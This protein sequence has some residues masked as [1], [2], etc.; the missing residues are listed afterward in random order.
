MRSEELQTQEPCRQL[1]LTASPILCDA[2]RRSYTQLCASADAK[3]S[4]EDSA[5]ISVNMT[6]LTNAAAEIPASMVQCTDDRFPL[7]TTYARFI[8]MLDRCLDRSF[9]QRKCYCGMNNREINDR[10]VTFERF[11]SHYYPQ[12]DESMKESVST[13][14][15]ELV[16][17]I[18][19]SIGALRTERGY[20]DVGD[21][22]NM[23]DQRGS[24]INRDRR[25]LIYQSFLKYERLKKESSQFDHLDLVHHVYRGLKGGNFE[26]FKMCRSVFIDEV[27]GKFIRYILIMNNYWFDDSL[28]HRF[29]SSGIG[30]AEIRM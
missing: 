19:G 6:H 7:I 3:P 13:V 27:Q 17:S 11:Q 23:S 30:R 24:S 9:F 8:R 15:G 2:I 12:F 20:I 16:S 22:E 26:E 14:Y 18:K 1:L 21:Y 28:W 5:Q 10:E 25:S 29:D 4:A